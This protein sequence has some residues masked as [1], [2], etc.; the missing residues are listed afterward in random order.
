MDVHYCLA[1]GVLFD[2]L[3]AAEHVA[4]E[5]GDETAVV[6]LHATTH[7]VRL[8]GTG[9][10]IGEY[11]YVKALEEGLDVRVDCRCLFVS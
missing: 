10:T 9:D 3:A 6:H 2:L 1:V 11:C 4:E 5:S 7:R 8:A